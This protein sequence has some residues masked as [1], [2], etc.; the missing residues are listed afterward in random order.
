MSLLSSWD[1]MDNCVKLLAD[2]VWADKDDITC[3]LSVEV[4]NF[5]SIIFGKTTNLLAHGAN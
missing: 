2:D 1:E 4:N 5:E 3:I